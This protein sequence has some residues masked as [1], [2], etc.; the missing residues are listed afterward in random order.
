MAKAT[1]RCRAPFLK[2]TG[3]DMLLVQPPLKK[4]VQW[5]W[6]HTLGKTT[7]CP[8]IAADVLREASSIQ[9]VAW[10]AIQHMA[11]AEMISE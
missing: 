4:A 5:W 7:S 8:I 10:E 2:V 1:N 11:C 9:H 3:E 6:K